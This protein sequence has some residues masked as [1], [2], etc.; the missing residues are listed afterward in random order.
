MTQ[1]HPHYFD[2]LDLRSDGRIV[3]YKRPIIGIRIGPFGQVSRTKG[4]FVKPAKITDAF[5]TRRFARLR[6]FTR[7]RG[8]VTDP[9]A[10]CRAAIFPILRHTAITC[11]LCASAAR[12]QIR[13]RVRNSERQQLNSVGISK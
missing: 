11:V 2:Y 12:A 4:F 10:V 5:E 13:W 9:M 7:D 8:P 1:S 3:L 6:A